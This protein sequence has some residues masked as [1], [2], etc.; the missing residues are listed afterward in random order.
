M[1]LM[2]IQELRP[3]GLAA[4]IEAAES[5]E[6]REARGDSRPSWSHTCSHETADGSVALV[7]H[8]ARPVEIRLRSGSADDPG[9]RARSL[10]SASV[11]KLR[12]RGCGLVR[13]TPDEA[14]ASTENW[15][16]GGWLDSIEPIA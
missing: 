13:L 5:S 9:G 14:A 8:E 6:A 3:P 12:C 10:L 15:D 7:S 11:L 4:A 2:G 16:G 1:N